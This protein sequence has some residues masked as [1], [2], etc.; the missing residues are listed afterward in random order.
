MPAIRR[1][2]ARL[3]TAMKP[4]AATLISLLNSMLPLLKP[5]PI[6]ILASFKQL[7]KSSIDRFSF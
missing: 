1:K 6:A 4:G 3:F 7:P 5:C 2:T